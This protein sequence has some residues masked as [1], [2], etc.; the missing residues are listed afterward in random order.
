VVES[1]KRDLEIRLAKA[2]ADGDLMGKQLGEIRG[3]KDDLVKQLAIAKAKVGEVEERERDREV[4]ATRVEEERREKVETL[5]EEMDEL[6]RELQAE[7]EEKE[8]VQEELD[9]V[10]AEIA[11]MADEEQRKGSRE[12]SLQEEV[13][14]LRE[15]LET[16]D[17]ELEQERRGRDEV[18]REIEQERSE[19]VKLETANREVSTPIFASTVA[20]SCQLKKALRAAKAD[21][22]SS[23]ATSEEVASLR[24]ELA[25]LRSESAS[26]DLDIVNLERRKAELKEDREMLNIALD[27]KQQELELV[28]G[29]SQWMRSMLFA[30]RLPQLTTRQVKRKYA[31]VSTPLTTSRRQNDATPTSAETDTPAPSKLGV[32]GAPSTAR[33]RRS[34]AAYTTPIVSARSG[35]HGVPLHAS[36]VKTA[37]VMRSVAEE[38]N[39]PPHG[40]GAGVGV[41]LRGGRVASFGSTRS[42]RVMMPA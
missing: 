23:S 7:Q 29:V 9:T 38:E 1:E 3:A 33:P 11:E 27:S 16:F 22:A 36:T 15:Q 30:G 2:L 24:N 28:S 42:A 4:A 17:T 12:Q 39:R 34:S 20:D 31:R 41:G 37:K 5:Q 32:G 14:S 10:R 40:E 25:R 19:R 26:K 35:R 18:E 6:R 8:R 13:E 21:Q